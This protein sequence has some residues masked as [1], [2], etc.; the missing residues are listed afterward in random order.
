MH[1]QRGSVVIRDNENS[2]FK[3]PFPRLLVSWKK[4]VSRDVKLNRMLIWKQL[5]RLQL[6]CKLFSLFPIIFIVVID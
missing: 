4:D 5:I 6:Y 3:S 1:L 2:F